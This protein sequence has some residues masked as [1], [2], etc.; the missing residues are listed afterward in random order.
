M[1][2]TN[3]VRT[4][5]DGGGLPPLPLLSDR[6]RPRR[7]GGGAVQGLA[8]RIAARSRGMADG[9]QRRARYAI[10]GFHRIPPPFPRR[11]VGHQE[12]ERTTPPFFPTVARKT[13]HTWP[14]FCAK[15][16]RGE[17]GNN[18][19]SKTTLFPSQGVPTKRCSNSSSS[20]T[21]MTAFR[22]KKNSKC[23]N[24]FLGGGGAAKLA[25]RSND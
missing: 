14:V 18:F 1:Q 22:G 6:I 8:G 24:F 10:C 2:R 19:L 9:E 20:T 15:R 12:A 11:E 16:K 17:R 5:I 7:R 13:H 4:R 25:G 3:C 23:D 21:M